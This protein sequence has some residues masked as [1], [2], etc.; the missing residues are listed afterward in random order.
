MVF[1][2]PKYTHT[3]TETKT[4][5]ETERHKRAY[6]RTSWCGFYR[7]QHITLQAHRYPPFLC[8]KFIFACRLSSMSRFRFGSIVCMCVCVRLLLCYPPSS[9]IR[10]VSKS[11]N[12]N[13]FLFSL[14]KS[15]CIRMTNKNVCWL[16]VLKQWNRKWCHS[17]NRKEF[18]SSFWIYPIAWSDCHCSNT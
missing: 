14:E 13:S 4:E 7:P 11:T 12:C 16:N 1:N 5:T 2:T 15:L 8:K 3:H 18:F 17:N 10:S 6:R 9:N